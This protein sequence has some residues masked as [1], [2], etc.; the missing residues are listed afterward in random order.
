[1]VKVRRGERQSDVTKLHVSDKSEGE[2]EVVQGRCEE[3]V[4]QS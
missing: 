2:F 1:M 4:E 3:C